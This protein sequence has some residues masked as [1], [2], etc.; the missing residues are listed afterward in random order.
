MDTYRLQRTMT[1]ELLGGF[2]RLKRHESQSRSNDYHVV[3]HDVE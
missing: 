1:L 2:L 3:L